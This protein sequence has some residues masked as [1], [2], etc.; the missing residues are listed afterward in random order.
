M[1][2]KNDKYCNFARTIMVNNNKI[3]CIVIL[4]CAAFLQFLL[5]ID[6]L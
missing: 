4:A 3:I 6:S 5:L 1:T 2:N